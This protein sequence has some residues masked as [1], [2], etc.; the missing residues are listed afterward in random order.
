MKSPALC[1]AI[2]LCSAT[3]ATAGDFAADLKK[4]EAKIDPV[5]KAWIQCTRQAVP[6][7][8]KSQAS[9][10]EVVTAVFASCGVSEHKFLLAAALLGLDSIKLQTQMREA[11]SEALTLDVIRARQAAGQ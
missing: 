4:M 8:A 1:L 10:T 5:A 11:A 2:A 9:V 7:L 3:A 6:G